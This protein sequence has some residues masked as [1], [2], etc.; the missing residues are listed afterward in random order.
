[1]VKI[2][3]GLNTVNTKWAVSFSGVTTDGTK[4]SH[5]ISGINFINPFVSDANASSGISEYSASPATGYTAEQVTAFVSNLLEFLG[6]TRYATPEIISG[7]F[8][9]V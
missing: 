9:I 3:N 8:S 5:S 2:A 1:L 6:E 7:K 4:K